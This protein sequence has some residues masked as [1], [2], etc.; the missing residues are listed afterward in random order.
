MPGDM[1]IISGLKL[2]C[3]DTRLSPWLLPVA[4]I[5]RYQD[6]RRTP[7][8]TPYVEVGDMVLQQNLNVAD[9]LLGSYEGEGNHSLCRQHTQAQQT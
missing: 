2:I 9:V 1:H 7:G 3:S 5:D 4:L 8:G 6:T